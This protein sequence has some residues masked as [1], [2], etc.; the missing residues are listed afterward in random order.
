M[1]S[2]AAIRCLAWSTCLGLFLF[3][4]IEAARSQ[5]PLAGSAPADSIANA[6]TPQPA[7]VERP[8]QKKS[9]HGKSDVFATPQPAGAQQGH[10]FCGR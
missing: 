8:E 7:P 2:R 4:A 1:N 3:V 6:Q 5:N 10:S 9:A